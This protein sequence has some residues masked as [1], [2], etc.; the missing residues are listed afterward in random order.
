MLLQHK[1]L[2]FTIALHSPEN[3][4]HNLWIIR[5]CHIIYIYV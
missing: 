3:L 4:K 5:L 2:K 1:K